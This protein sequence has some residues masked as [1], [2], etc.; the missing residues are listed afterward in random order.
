M[1]K[2]RLW[3]AALILGLALAFLAKT[4]LTGDAIR[5]ARIVPSIAALVGT[6]IALLLW[7]LFLS[8]LPTRVRLLGLAASVLAVLAGGALF[9]IRGVTGDL[10]PVLEPRWAGP[11]SLPQAPPAPPTSATAPTPALPAP[12]VDSPN[13]SQP[14]TAVKPGNAVPSASAAPSATAEPAAA[15]PQFLGPSR[16]GTLDGPSLARDWSAQP[17]RRLW[18]QPIGAAW[19]GFAVADGVAVTQEQRGHQ[20][21]VVA[22]QAATG[23]VLWDQADAARYENVIAGVGP[24]AT[25]TIAGERVFTLGAMG[26]LNAFD[27]R[28]GRRLWSRQVLS[29]NG[30]TLPEWGKSCSP[31]VIENRVIVSAG[32]PDGRSLVAYDAATGSAVWSGG[33]DRSSYS[34]PRLALLAGRPQLLVLNS[35]SVAAHDPAS[36]AVLWEQPF[37][38]E[39]PNV[40]T[41][42]P[43]P[44]DR[45]LVSAGYGIGSRLYQVAAVE[46]GAL[47]ASLLWASPRLKSKFANLLVHAGSVYGLDDGLLTCLDPAT[48]ERRW[49][50]GRYGHGQVILV[51]ALLLVQ[52]EEGELVLIDPSPDGLR[53][54]TRFQALDGKTWNPPALAGSLLVVRN[55]LEAAAYALPVVK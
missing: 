33:S 10:V 48:G 19:S 7:L 17:P 45:V 21:H 27:R 20:E 4:W 25:P 50:A 46:G 24:R 26:I 22:Y 23:R 37:P 13:P 14:P 32:G 9:R 38:S 41:P 40:T 1:L 51:G 47:T 49:K 12:A 15:Y 54:L 11:A 2:P 6:C 29:D 52:T 35:A 18:R 53:E 8:R 39:Q 31:L 43:L 44:G 55:D 16:D 28:S 34:S 36:G 3:P 42:A 30:A 5:Q